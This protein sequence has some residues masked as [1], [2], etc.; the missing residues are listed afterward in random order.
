MENDFNPVENKEAQE[1][2]LALISGGHV[3]L[4]GPPGTAKTLLIETFANCFT[5]A[6][7][8]KIQFTPDIL[9]SDIIGFRM[10][11]PT[12]GDWKKEPYKGPIF[13]HFVLADEI[14]RAPPKAHSALLEAMQEGKVSMI[15]CEKPL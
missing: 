8:S 2:I 14:N 5:D 1:I 11:D 6:T 15:G 9:P 4:E 13:N 10:L 3:L 7:H 12:T